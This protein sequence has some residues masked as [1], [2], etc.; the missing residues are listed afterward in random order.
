[1]K[2]FK[3]LLITCLCAA[4][5]TSSMLPAAE[6]AAN[7]ASQNEVTQNITTDPVE[8]VPATVKLT[9]TLLEYKGTEQIPDVTAVYDNY[10]NL[11]DASNYEVIKPVNSIMIG[12]YTI[13]VVFNGENYSGELD[14][15]YKIIPKKT[16]F[17]Y[18]TP[19]VSGFQ[20]SWK[21]QETFVEGY[22]IQYATKTDFS[23]AVI[24][25]YKAEKT[26]A[27]IEKLKGHKKYYVRIRTY[28]KVDGVKYN[29]SWSAAEE[30]KTRTYADNYSNIN[31]IEKAEGLQYF[32]T[33]KKLSSATMTGLKNAMKAITNKGY[34]VSFVMMDLDTGEGIANY[35]DRVH[36]GASTIKGPYVCAISEFATTKAKNYR[37]YITPT[38]TMS[39]NKCYHTLRRNFGS[40]PITQYMEAA[41]TKIGTG[42]WVDFTP[43]KLSCLWVKNWEFFESGKANAE[44]TKGVFNRSYQSFINA[45]LKNSKTEVY[46]KPGWIGS[47]GKYICQHDAGIVHK[48]NGHT[49]LITVLSTAYGR[50]PLLRQLVAE[51]DK[52]EEELIT[53]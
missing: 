22:Q 40:A 48:S 34:R 53:E 37:A 31:K 10:G 5:M 24:K 52:C 21:A 43:R 46:S 47:S 23:D 3:K 35:V 1:M 16:S 18:L 42:T 14:K 2:K 9:K 30:L 44:W 50:A 36:Y 51:L 39:D 15:V 6:A 29:S 27:K 20:A 11:I 17:K 41:H 26:F 32:R 12:A 25:N 19:R 45:Q 49:Y 8:M 33:E 13:K 28:Y 38:I 4:M 7:E